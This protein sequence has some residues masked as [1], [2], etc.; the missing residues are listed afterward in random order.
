MVSEKGDRVMA[1]DEH[2]TR[3]DRLITAIDALTNMLGRLIRL[4]ELGNKRSER[5]AS[6]RMRGASPDQP[7]VVTP[8]VQAA[9]RRAL[10]K[11]GR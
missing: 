8:I 2:A 5:T 9:V 10:A 4:L 6:T 3:L 11:L 7:I 1:P